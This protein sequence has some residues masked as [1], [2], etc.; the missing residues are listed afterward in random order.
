MNFKELVEEMMAVGGLPSQQTQSTSQT[1]TPSLNTDQEEQPNPDTQ[2]PEN[3]LNLKLEDFLKKANIPN[4][5]H[6]KILKDIKSIF[7]LGGGQMKQSLKNKALQYFQSGKWRSDLKSAVMSGLYK[8]WKFAW[9]Q[10]TG[11]VKGVPGAMK[12]LADKL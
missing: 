10:V 2:Q 9:G 7:V 4:T 1:Q 5:P 11:A 12:T 3:I 8:T 6:N